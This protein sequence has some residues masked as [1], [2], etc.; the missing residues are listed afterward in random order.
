M[1]RKIEIIAMNFDDYMEK[2]GY[3]YEAGEL[4]DYPLSE[5]DYLL[6]ESESTRFALVDDRLYEVEICD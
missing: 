1:E 5:I 4:W 2:Y 6:C 3:Y